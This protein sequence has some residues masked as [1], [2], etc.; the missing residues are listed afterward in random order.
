MSIKKKATNKID[1]AHATFIRNC[2]LPQNQIVPHVSFTD[3]KSNSERNFPCTREAFARISKGS[4][5]RNKNLRNGLAKASARF[6]FLLLIEDVDKGKMVTGVH[7]IPI[8]K[9]MDADF[10]VELGNGH[11]QPN[12]AVVDIY[13]ESG[14][15]DLVAYPAAFKSSAGKFVTELE[16]LTKIDHFTEITAGDVVFRVDAINGNEVVFSAER[17][18][19]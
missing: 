8:P 13:P 15:L 1:R 7:C 19:K 18:K 3:A 9:Y 6:S 10:A 11:L 17:K 2:S 16:K 4:G 14:E 12:S 5:S